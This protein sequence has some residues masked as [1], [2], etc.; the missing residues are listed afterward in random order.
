MPKGRAW[1]PEEEAQ[2]S[3]LV[4]ACGH[5]WRLIE[6][7]WQG[8]RRAESA[9]A[10]H[11]KV[12][13]ARRAELSSS[14][15]ES[16]S[17]KEHLDAETHGSSLRAATTT[18]QRAAMSGSGLAQR[19]QPTKANNCP[20]VSGILLRQLPW[21]EPTA[22]LRTPWCGRSWARAAY[23]LIRRAAR[24]GGPQLDRDLQP[25]HVDLA[26]AL[27]LDEATPP[28]RLLYCPTVR[29]LRL[30]TKHLATTHACG[31][32]HA[33]GAAAGA[34]ID[35]A[36]RDRLQLVYYADG[37]PQRAA[38][39]IP[40]LIANGY[41]RAL[42]GGPDA[43][44]VHYAGADHYIAWLGLTG[45]GTR[46]AGEAARAH[47]NFKYPR[48]LVHA[49]GDS[50]ALQMATAA[51]VSAL[52]ATGAEPRGSIRYVSLYAGAFDGFLRGLRWAQEHQW[53]RARIV[54]VLAA[55]RRHGRRR[56]LRANTHYEMVVGSAAKAAAMQL[57]DITVL[58]ASPECPPLSRGRLLG[59]LPAARRFLKALKAV[60]AF[61]RTMATAI[62]NMRPRVVLI[63]Q[64]AGIATHY[65]Q[66]LRLLLRTLRKACKE[67]TWAGHMARA[68][69]M[70]APHRRHRLILAATRRGAPRGG[71]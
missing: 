61:A 34:R 22:G 60:R 59:G 19:A 8:R 4:A 52:R 55:E 21:E 32:A 47:A 35:L 62:R 16:G 36:L 43:K 58:A 68:E 49:A 10:H 24:P 13:Q 14:A 42:I 18:A 45:G 5:Q 64:V 63:E 66:L 54:P 30:W 28:H 40:C 51:V 41:R 57:E 31:E 39:P 2:L 53:P 9:L 25:A 71:G 7:K 70:R 20:V 1:K 37:G 17:C 12:M 48:H 46:A 50:I 27:R 23:T 29:A 3:K 11:W 15:S 67:Y 44:G 69:E 33:T 65:P 26:W 38:T 6:S 56:L